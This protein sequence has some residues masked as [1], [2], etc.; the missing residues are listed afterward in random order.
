MKIKKI[1]LIGICLLVATLG[2][3][4]A[5]AAEV[6]N[7]TMSEVLGVEHNIESINQDKVES[8]N[9]E[10]NKSFK[11][12][13]EYTP[14]IFIK[15]NNKNPIP[16]KWDTNRNNKTN[17][18]NPNNNLPVKV[19]DMS[20]INITKEPI[21]LKKSKTF[22]YKGEKVFL[23]LIENG[24]D[25]KLVCYKATSS[26]LNGAGSSYVAG[27]GAELLKIAEDQ[28]VIKKMA[29]GAAWVTVKVTRWE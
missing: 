18:H 26:G 7:D 23:A 20:H 9:E 19:A 29:Y 27:V 3:T 5:S 8:I 25:K 24:T 13:E 12:G 6:N 14:A 17:N 16:V 28:G 2:L 22:N 11:G 1:L 15:D 10:K 4:A 21:I